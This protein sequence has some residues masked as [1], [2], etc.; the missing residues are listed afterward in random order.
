MNSKNHLINDYLRTL[1]DDLIKKGY[2]NESQEHIL[3]SLELQV[4]ELGGGANLT[5]D[6]ELGIISALS[7]ADSYPHFDSDEEDLEEALVVEQTEMNSEVGVQ[8]RVTKELEVKHSSSSKVRWI[9]MAGIV[10]LLLIAIKGISWGVKTQQSLVTYEED[11]KSTRAQVDNVIQRRYD[12]IPNLVNTVKGYAV[13]EKDLFTE[14]AKLRSNWTKESGEQRQKTEAQLEGSISRLLL[15]AESYP[16][17]KSDQLYQNLMMSLESTENRIAIERR[18]NNESIR[19]FN[20]EI[21]KMPRSLI[22]TLMGFTQKSE[23]IQI[24]DEVRV[25][26]KV[27]F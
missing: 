18:R 22:A 24:K 7:P 15:V 5:S 14:I 6:Q 1:S 21:R 16:N 23:Y 12:L 11:V 20:S 19:V 26:P 10:L 25:N 4:M 3:S 2:D 13:H 27:E 17:I 9:L 8:D